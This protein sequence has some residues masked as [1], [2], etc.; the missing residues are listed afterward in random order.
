MFLWAIYIFLWSVCL[1]WC[2]KIGGPNVGINRSL[3]D[4]LVWKLGL[5]GCA[6]PFLGIHKSK[7][8]CSVH[9]AMAIP[10]IYSFSGNCA[11]SA[12]ISTF[13]CLWAIYIF[14]GSVHIFPPAEKADPSWEYIIRSQTHECGNWDWGCAISFL[15][16]HKSKFLCSVQIQRL[17]RSV[18]AI[19]AAIVAAGWPTPPCQFKPIMKGEEYKG[20]DI[21][22]LMPLSG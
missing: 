20:G 15:G 17:Q 5:G 16:I 9:T 6:F 7:F 4:A 3:T 22:I 2:R 19:C 1:F 14:P 12:P 10:F 13:M 21:G 18:E 8:L 11:A